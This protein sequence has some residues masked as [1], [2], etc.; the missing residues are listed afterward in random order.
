MASTKAV[1]GTLRSP[2]WIMLQPPAKS[3][4]KFTWFGQVCGTL[5]LLNLLVMYVIFCSVLQKLYSND[6]PHPAPLPP[7][8]T[9]WP[10]LN[11]SMHSRAD[12]VHSLPSNLNQY[13]NQTNPNQ[14]SQS[15]ASSTS[16]QP[17][18]RILSW[19]SGSRRKD[20]PDFDSEGSELR[21]KERPLSLDVTS[22]YDGSTTDCLPPQEM[23]VS[24]REGDDEVDLV[25]KKGKIR[26]C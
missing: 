25:Q 11:T 7:T 15:Q 1:A 21:F 10:G 13:R 6:G 20:L 5:S 22:N 14:I 2:S 18:K 19:E 8:V 17:I 26:I 4:T 12:R 23:Q 24:P 16:S 3:V 9:A